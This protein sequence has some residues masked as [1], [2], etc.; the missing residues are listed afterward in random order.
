[1]A[2]I[3]LG[4]EILPFLQN[5]S[6]LVSQKIITSIFSVDSLSNVSFF[7]FPLN[8]YSFETVCSA[9]KRAEAKK[10]WSL[11]SALFTTAYLPLPLISYYTTLPEIDTAD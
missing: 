10:H 1:M 7:P 8:F 4:L 5:E 2:L 3:P 6:G 11:V 9:C